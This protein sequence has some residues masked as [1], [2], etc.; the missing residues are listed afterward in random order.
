MDPD[1]CFRTLVS[2]M[3]KYI[4]STHHLINLRETAEDPGPRSFQKVSSWLGSVVL[5]S[6]PTPVV[7]WKLHGCAK[8]WLH[9]SLNILKQHYTST[10][11]ETLAQCRSMDLHR[12]EEA[13]V[14]AA[15]WAR[16]KLKK[17]Q[18]STIE[19]AMGRIRHLWMEEGSATMGS[20]DLPVETGRVKPLNSTSQRGEQLGKFQH[21]QNLEVVE[22]E[23]KDGKVSS[24]KTEDLRVQGDSVTPA[25]VDGVEEEGIWITV[26]E[27]ADSNTS[28]IIQ[29]DEEEGKKREEKE[30]VGRGSGR[31]T[32][33]SAGGRGKATTV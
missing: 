7:G 17:I 6:G 18:Q 20:R 31:H 19:M 21:K 32:K 16:R 30:E 1:D 27:V 33:K 28:Q 5:P 24:N 8:R 23:G 15:R 26:D 12:G 13:L 2:L 29:E 10:Q 4:K 14:V 3:H 25:I 22:S 9:E 11:E